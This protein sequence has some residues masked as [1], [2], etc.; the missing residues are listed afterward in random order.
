MEFKI[1]IGIIGPSAAGKSTLAEAAAGNFLSSTY[2]RTIKFQKLMRDLVNPVYTDK[3]IEVNKNKS[4]LI[5]WDFG[6]QNIYREFI[7]SLMNVGGAFVY[8]IDSTNESSID[9][10]INQWIPMINE[11]FSSLGLNVPP[12]VVYISK[13]QKED[14]MVQFEDNKSD[15]LDEVTDKLSSYDNIKSFFYGDVLGNKSNPTMFLFKGPR[16]RMKLETNIIGPLSMA[17]I[18]AIQ[19]QGLSGLIDDYNTAWLKTNN[20]EAR[21]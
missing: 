14:S 20:L 18:Y 15:Y 8:T 11:N 12:A 10:L 16:E 3:T 1:P 4:K 9:E 7:S 5:L 13:T 2:K 21:F 6:G 19:S 17:G